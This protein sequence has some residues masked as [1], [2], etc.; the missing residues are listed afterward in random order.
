MPHP[1]REARVCL[2]GDYQRRSQRQIKGHS[3]C[4]GGW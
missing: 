1:K 4:H 3:S 2:Q